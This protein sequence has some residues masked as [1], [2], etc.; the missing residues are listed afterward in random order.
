MQATTAASLPRT[1]RLRG[2]ELLGE[3]NSQLASLN[4]ASGHV[5]VCAVSCE[6]QP[7]VTRFPSLTDYA[8]WSVQDFL[9]IDNTKIL[10]S[11]SLYAL[12]FEIEAD[13]FNHS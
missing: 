11:P 10:Q 3:T 12:C 5:W 6:F 9:S 1:T 8:Y 13:F 4:D 2:L 7:L